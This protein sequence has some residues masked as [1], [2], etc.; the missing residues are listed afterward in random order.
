MKI[1]A[2]QVSLLNLL[3]I[4]RPL[5]ARQLPAGLSI[6]SGTYDRKALTLDFVDWWEI[7]VRE[8]DET[9][10]NLPVFGFLQSDES[11]MLKNDRTT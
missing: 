1:E 7:S 6:Q 8:Y 4:Q 2:Q 5:Q 11:A 10:R 3:Q 9:L